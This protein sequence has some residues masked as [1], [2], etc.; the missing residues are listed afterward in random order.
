MSARMFGDTCAAPCGPA[1]SNTGSASST[2][3]VAVRFIQGCD[4][5]DRGFVGVGSVDVGYREGHA[6]TGDAQPRARTEHA[7]P[8][9]GTTVGG[10]HT[11]PGR[12]G[13]PSNNAEGE[14]SGV[15]PE[16]TS[17][18]R[19]RSCQGAKGG[20]QLNRAGTPTLHAHETL[21]TVVWFPIP[22][23]APIQPDRPDFSH[24]TDLDLVPLQPA[25]EG[26]AAA[27]PSARTGHAERPGC[28]QGLIDD[29]L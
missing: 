25:I 27:N 17:A 4:P 7:V 29:T 28:K 24:R 1:R 26:S 23:A 18:A 2:C 15:W 14:Y 19:H 12:V 5:A 22:P 21:S 16:V 10:D 13:D 8:A 11:G 3:R 20:H 9:V 6:P